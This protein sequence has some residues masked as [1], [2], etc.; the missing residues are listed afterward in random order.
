[1]WQKSAAK[2]FS[3]ALTTTFLA[4]SLV[5]V[6]TAI[7]AVFFVLNQVAFAVNLNNESK[8]CITCHANT[9]LKVEVEGEQLSLYIDTDS[10]GASVHGGVSCQTC[11]QEIQLPH[12]NT[13]YGSELKR[14]VQN[15]CLTCHGDL[16]AGYSNSIHGNTANSGDQGFCSDCHGAAH[17]ITPTSSKDS[18]V[19]KLNVSPTC[20]KCHQGKVS[21]SYNRSF[22]GIALRFGWEEAASCVDCHGSHDILPVLNSNA[23][24]SKQN[25]PK[26]CV[27]CHGG[28]ASASW[29][30]GS[31]HTTFEDKENSFLLWIVWKI[32]I[33]LILIDIIKDLPIIIF[34][35]LKQLKAANAAHRRNKK[36][37]RDIN[38]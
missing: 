18:P 28:E 23:M 14:D 35:L 17:L 37:E 24:V 36:I 15:S 27:S 8:I 10:F 19:H 38:F 21:E 4:V 6:A 22:H 29:S 13:S 16:K 32:F 7:F 30:E 5:T 20:Q 33:V 9:D 26:T 25:L 31:E 2:I 1:M 12:K 34:E 3:Y 11:H